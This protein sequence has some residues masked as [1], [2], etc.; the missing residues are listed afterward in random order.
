MLPYLSGR[1]GALLHVL[2]D[3]D[4]PA[5]LVGHLSTDALGHLSAVLSGHLGAH[6]LGDLLLRRRAHVLG[7]RLT[8]LP[9]LQVTRLRRKE[10]RIFKIIFPSLGPRNF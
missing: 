3:G 1:V 9:R 6:L 4:G 2:L 10:K 8:L 5:L 7:N